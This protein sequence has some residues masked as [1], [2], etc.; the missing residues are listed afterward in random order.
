[1]SDT[2]LLTMGGAVLPSG[3]ATFSRATLVMTVPAGVAVCA[4]AAGDTTSAPETA[5]GRG[6]EN[7]KAFVRTTGL[8]CTSE[9]AQRG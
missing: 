4:R 1:V 8:S 5:R 3:A 2:L 6:K 7:R 9:K